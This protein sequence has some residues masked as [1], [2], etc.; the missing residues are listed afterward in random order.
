MGVCWV[1]G[2]GVVSEP[3]FISMDEAAVLIGVSRDTIRRMVMSGRVPALRFGPR[4]IR[5]D[6]EALL[7][8]VVLCSQRLFRGRWRCEGVGVGVGG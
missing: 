7:A 1:C 6:R 2:G 8:G 5:V 3:V 4:L